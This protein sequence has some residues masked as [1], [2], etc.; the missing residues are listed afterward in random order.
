MCKKIKLKNGADIEFPRELVHYL[1]HPLVVLG[2]GRPRP[3]KIVDRIPSPI[4]RK[5]G[6]VLIKKMVPTSGRYDDFEKRIFKIFIRRRKKSKR[7]I[8][9]LANQRD[10]LDRMRRASTIIRKKYM[11]RKV[12]VEHFS[13]KPKRL[14]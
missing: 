13:K 1:K 12:K 9:R 7:D 10:P 4:Q 2:H 5:F 6:S 14:K 11:G 8:V 3:R